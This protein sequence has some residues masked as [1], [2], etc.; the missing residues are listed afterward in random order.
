MLTLRALGVENASSRP[1]DNSTMLAN[2][3]LTLLDYWS[4][5]KL[6]Q[7]FFS[8][9]QQSQNEPYLFL[10][11]VLETLSFWGMVLEFPKKRA[12]LPTSYFSAKWE[13]KREY[14]E[15]KSMSILDQLD[16]RWFN[17]T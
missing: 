13:Q 7:R 8:Q 15:R 14:E 11:H 3:P 5:D 10:R 4:T 16:L 9:S 12:P 1:V 17:P 6:L 2:Q